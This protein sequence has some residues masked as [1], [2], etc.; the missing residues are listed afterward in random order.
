LKLVG[1]LPWRDEGINNTFK[2]WTSRFAN[3]RRAITGLLDSLDIVWPTRNKKIGA[4]WKFDQMI[5]GNVQV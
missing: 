1:G 5:Y 2:K 4:I 3:G